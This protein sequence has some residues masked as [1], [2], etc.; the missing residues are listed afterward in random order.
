MKSYQAIEQQISSFAVQEIQITSLRYEQNLMNYQYDIKDNTPFH[1]GIFKLDDKAWT[2]PYLYDKEKRIRKI[3]YYAEDPDSMNLA[4]LYVRLYNKSFS[5]PIFEYNKKTQ[6]LKC[7][8]YSELPILLTRALLLFE[9]KQLTSK[10]FCTNHP[11]V[12]FKKVPE[13]AIKELKR[14]FSDK[15]IIIKREENGK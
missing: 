3:S 14:I 1:V 10:E 9:P 15:T 7:I 8:R 11:S 13:E 4:R 12:P 2:S 6:E 5:S